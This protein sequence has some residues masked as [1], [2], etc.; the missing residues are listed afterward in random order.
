MSKETRVYGVPYDY[1]WKSLSDSE[2]IKIAEEHGYIYSLAGFQIAYNDEDEKDRADWM[3]F[4]NHSI[5]FIEVGDDEEILCANCEYEIEEDI[6][7]TENLI[8]HHVMKGVI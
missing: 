8:N 6:R 2:F 1:D 3:K 4:Q 7:D 5:R